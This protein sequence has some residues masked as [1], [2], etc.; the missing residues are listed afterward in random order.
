M[1]NWF[2]PWNNCVTSEGVAT[3]DCIPTI[4]INLITALFAFA[5]ITA[6]IMFILGSYKLISS[7]GDLKKVQ[8]AKN[9][10]TYGL[11]GLAV[12]VFALAIIKLI[13]IVTGVSCITSFG[14]TACP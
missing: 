12:V 1:P 3:L 13:S 7:R 4:F 6:L 11:L 14:F 9:N 5:G 10:F 8:G 2:Q